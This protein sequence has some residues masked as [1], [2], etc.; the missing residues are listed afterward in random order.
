MKRE[1]ISWVAL[2]VAVIALV[3]SQWS[4]MLP[5]APQE[6]PIP[7]EGIREAR[8][9]SSAF[10]AVAEFV[11][12][13]VVQIT[14]QRVRTGA[15]GGFRGP[16]GQP[17]T[18]EDFERFFREFGNRLPEGFRFEPQQTIVGSG[19]GVV[20][21]REGHILTNNHVV[22]NARDGA[23]EV[24]F[25]DGTV[26]PAEVVGLDPQTDLAVVKVSNRQVTPVAIG[27][28]EDL[29]V[30]QWVMAIG[31]PF[32]LQQTVT[33]GIISA[34]HRTTVGILGQNG[35]EDFIQTDA[36]INPGN[37]GGPLVDIQGRVIGIN[38]AIATQSR[39]N[40]GVGFAIP[41]D[42]ATYVADA[43]IES[44]EVQRAQLGV[45]ISQVPTEEAEARGIP[46]GRV[47]IF[48]ADVLRDGPAD[49][50]GLKAGDIIIGFRDRPVTSSPDFRFDVSRSQPNQ[51]YS[52]TYLRDGQTRTTQVT[53]EPM[54]TELL[55][56]VG[57]PRGP[58]RR[59]EIV[60]IADYGLV[61]SAITPELVDR[62][63]L[64]EEVEGIYVQ[65]VAEDSPAA[66]A[67]VEAGDI[68]TRV[69]VDQ[70][71]RSITDPRMLGQMALQQDALTLIILKPSGA[72]D[73]VTLSTDD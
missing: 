48:V 70:R 24:T 30:G 63:G 34:T 4:R 21:D 65:E 54:D 73:Y 26:L 25:A 64:D 61:V 19:S 62:Y 10:E 11:G 17:M 60:S 36:A 27:S 58:G 28:S 3:G 57:D 5:A 46:E 9:L 53:L 55:A 40:A 50:A 39:S 66:K 44:G 14:T 18:P 69:V 16:N 51:S 6:T 8:T 42:L 41:I 43:I 12:P 37:S 35:Y 38:S 20:Y 71:R 52:L 72:Y 31:S 47:G 23:I 15:G 59:L 67:G 45:R 33:A 68:I 22:E 1:V 13:S 7:Q 56:S 49:E 29:K 2:A 32:G